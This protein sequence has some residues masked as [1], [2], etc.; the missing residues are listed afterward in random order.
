MAVRALDRVT[1]SFGL[2]SIPTRIYST[3]KPSEDISFHLLHAKDGVRLKQQMVCPKD[4]E[5]V[6]RDETIRGFEY[7]KG[8]YVTLT[9]EELDALEAQ[10][11]DAI[12]IREFV[13]MSAVDPIYVDRS[14][15]LGPD[16]GGDKAFALLSR[17]LAAA[18]VAGVAQYAARGKA[19][20]VLVR[21]FEDGLI[22]HQLR[23]PDEIRSYGEVGLPEHPR[24]KAGELELAGKVIEQL[25][26]DEFHPE[27]YRDEVKE[28]TRAALEKKRK[29][30]EDITAPEPEPAVKVVDLMEALKQSLGERKPAKPR[31]AKRHGRAASA[32]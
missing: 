8:K 32:R 9:E 12:E 7:A 23:Y 3:T 16:K 31:R 26:T 14:Y 24:I 6:P 19:Y 1:I 20:V 22:M 2:V 4:G 18:D 25:A 13:P 5:V 10:A 11:S 28:R 21:A 30:G 15:Y 27:R 17:A 29:S